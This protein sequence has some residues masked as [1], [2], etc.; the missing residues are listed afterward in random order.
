MSENVTPNAEAEDALDPERYQFAERFAIGESFSVLCI[1][2]GRTKRSMLRWLKD[3]QVQAVIRR[4]RSADMSAVAGKAQQGMEFAIDQLRRLAAS[5]DDR[6]SLAASKAIVDTTLKLRA[7][8]EYDGRL[9]EV[10]DRLGI[11]GGAKRQGAAH[12]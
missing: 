4:I 3:P 11:G 7:F 10:E 9:R 2:F 8:E 1:E 12:A 5:S 6:T